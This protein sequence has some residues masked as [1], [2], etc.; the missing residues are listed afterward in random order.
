VQAFWKLVAVLVILSA[1]VGCPSPRQAGPRVTPL[2]PSPSPAP[3]ATGP[4][5]PSIPAVPSRESAT[6]LPAGVRPTDGWVSWRD[7]AVALGCDQPHRLKNF[8]EPTYKLTT[9]HGNFVIT[10]GNRTA[11]WNGFE[12][13][14]GFG[15]RVIA[16]EPFL[17]AL[18]LAK[19]FQPLLQPAARAKTRLV[20]IDPGHGGENTGTRSVATHRYEKEFTLDWAFR[21]ERL[22]K[23]RGW[24]VVLTR[25]KDV[26]IP[27]A[28]R[29]QIAE[30]LQADLFLSLHFNSS[31]GTNGLVDR[32]GL[33]TYCLTPLGMPSTLPRE[34]EDDPGQIFP[35]NAF[36]EQ[37]F[38][39][40][41]R[42]HEALLKA[43]GQKDRGVRRARFMA[44]LRTQNRPAALVE[45]G[46]LS[47]PREARLI[48]QQA[49][50]QKLAEGVAQAFD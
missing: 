3:A 11:F 49:Y 4:I 7:W 18:D 27:L 10:I 2:A 36:D 21:L 46:F 8:S 20:V 38:R 30:H 31:N 6:Q 32:G 48:E 29:V 45:G 12:F 26:D 43:T 17:H 40:A 13:A 34:F 42:I 19:N 16:G 28:D 47:N 44:V 39:F 50:R 15:P 9:G 23:Q 14:L 1:L 37:N 25:T 35:N 24:N 5:A 41:M 22:L 33:E